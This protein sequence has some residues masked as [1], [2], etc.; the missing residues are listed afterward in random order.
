V[1]SGKGLAITGLPQLILA[2][3]NLLLDQHGWNAVRGKHFNAERSGLAEI[4]Q[5]RAGPP[6][7]RYRS[8]F[9]APGDPIDERLH[10]QRMKDVKPPVAVQLRQV[11]SLG[12]WAGAS[13]AASLKTRSAV[14]LE[15]ERFLSHGLA[16]AHRD[17]DNH[18]VGQRATNA[19]ANERTSWTLS[20]WG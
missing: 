15:R 20:G 5:G 4:A 9:P 10:K 2:N 14:E 7:A 12:P 13:L 8:T 11:E 6:D 3:A 19:K 1:F 16:G 17:G 18:Q